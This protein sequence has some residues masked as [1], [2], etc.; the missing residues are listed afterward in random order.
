MRDFYVIHFYFPFQSDEIILYIF[1]L[2]L[3]ISFS[4]NRQA[5]RHT[6]T[7]TYRESN[8]VLLGKTHSLVPYHH[9]IFR[10]WNAVDY[11]IV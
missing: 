5:Q 9:F 3:Y 2:F 7:H 4:N 1:V 10:H 11:E 6:N 8:N